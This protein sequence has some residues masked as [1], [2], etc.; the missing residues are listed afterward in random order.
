MHILSLFDGISCGRV[1]LERANIPVTTYYAAEIDPNAITVTQDN[2]PDT[3]QMGCVTGWKDWDIDWS[4]IDLLMGGSPCQGFSTAGWQR[5]MDDPRSALFTV[6]VEILDHIKSLNPDVKFL[7]ENVPMK[8][9][10]LALISGALDVPPVQINSTLVSA[11]SRRRFYWTNIWEIAQP[12]D[13]G[14]TMADI[15]DGPYWSTRDKS[16]AITATYYKG[17]NFRRYF[18]KSGRQLVLE[19]G[20]DPRPYLTDL[21]AN[22]IARADGSRYRT[23]TPEE[24]EKLQTLPVGYTSVIAAKTHRYHMIGNGWTVDVIAHILRPLAPP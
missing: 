13:L 4:K 3:R 21:E 14:L 11:Q 23:L 2:Y 20:Y 6:F 24:C 15:I 22:D 8:K 7:L 5:G 17:S 18:F 16:Y 9:E 1:A 12:A 19:N 10:W